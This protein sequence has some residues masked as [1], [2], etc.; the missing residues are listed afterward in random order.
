L[1]VEVRT[2]ATVF[3][4]VGRSAAHIKAVPESA[5]TA[6]RDAVLDTEAIQNL[7]L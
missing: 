1:Q 7:Y 2:G 4:K 5:Y 3:S 6:I